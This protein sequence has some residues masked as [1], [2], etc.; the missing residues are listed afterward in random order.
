MPVRNVVEAVQDALRVAMAGDERV[1]VLGQDVGKLGGVFRA[2]DGLL[3]EFGP[4]R[5]V[6]TPLSEAG[7]VGT[8]IGLA[9]YGLLPVAE[10]QFA[11]FIYPGF[12]Q[13]V[14]EMAKLRY[15]SAG[16]Y[17]APMVVR[18]PIGGGVRGGLY[19]SQSPEAHFAHV[20]GLKVVMPSD[21]YDAKGLLL[22]A[23]ADPDPVVFF[24]PKRVYRAVR[25]EVP[26]GDYRVPLGEARV[27][28]A[29]DGVTVVTW[30]AMVHE[31]ALAAETAAKDG[32]AVELLDL[33]TLVPFDG[34][35]VARSVEKTGRLVVVHEAPQ[36]AGFGAEVVAQVVERCF[37]A[38]EAP[39]E[40]VCGL[41]TPVPYA[42]EADYLPLS[43]RIAAAVARVCAER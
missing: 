27:R 12:D 24:E 13:I 18:A 20:A 34:D 23:I 8:A 28:R 1:L 22:S 17:T 29:G 26:N 39:P 4:D 42:L 2:T 5:V 19:H 37:Y 31:A 36:T 41:D 38:L 33:R 35:A 25:C 43:P 9:M 14:S 21:P 6:D 7:I 40:R 15:R 32:I 11:D 30:G 10:I 16:Q 3:A